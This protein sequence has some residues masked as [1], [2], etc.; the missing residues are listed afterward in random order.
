MPRSP[1][2]DAVIR[3]DERLKHLE[4]DMIELKQRNESMD[5]N[6]AKLAGYYKELKGRERGSKSTWALLLGGAGGL[7]GILALLRSFIH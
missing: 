3:I 7:T 2:H 6:L 4:E 5:G 1:N